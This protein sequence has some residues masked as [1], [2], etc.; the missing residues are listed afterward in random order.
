MSTAFHIKI[1]KQGYVEKSYNFY[2]QALKITHIL[3]CFVTEC[4][5]LLLHQILAQN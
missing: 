3:E 4:Q 5:L 1:L 2:C